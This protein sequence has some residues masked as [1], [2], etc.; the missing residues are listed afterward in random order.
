MLDQSYPF[1][2]YR[3]QMPL[4]VRSFLVLLATLL[5]SAANAQ[6]QGKT[7][8]LDPGHPSEV[9]R[10][11]RGKKLAEMKV[12]WDMAMLLKPRLEKLGANVVLTKASIGQLVT[13]RARAEVAN[14]A[15]A[16]LMLRL[17]CDAAAGS[18]F[19]SFYPTQPGKAHGVSGPS[20][21][22]LAKVAPMAKRFHRS[23]AKSMK[24]KLNDLG[25][26]SDLKTAVG[27][28]QGALTGSIFSD[29]PAILVELVVLTN[30]KDE[31]FIASK[32]GQRFYA[33][34]LAQAVVAALS[35]DP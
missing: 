14:K 35:Q 11:T 12:V 23:L 10:G 29:V 33:A 5:A 3:N 32:K 7:V 19:A 16:D 27:A 25:L 6:L 30:P 2:S 24:G 34:A 20:K 18:G 17:H 28:K 15:G 8:C 13:N 9:G 26:K 31:A 4:P 21:E 1:E 22:M